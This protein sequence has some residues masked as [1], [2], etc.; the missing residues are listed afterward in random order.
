MYH[1]H[2]FVSIIIGFSVLAFVGCSNP[3]SKYSKVEGTVTLDGQP[4]EGVTVTF[5]P[6]EQGLEG[7]VGRTNASGQFSLTSTG[8][9]QGG[10]GVLPGEYRVTVSKSQ[11]PVDPDVEA[12]EQG[13]ITY[14]EVQKRMDARDPSRQLEAK[15]L[16]PEKYTKL[17][18]TDL[19]AMVKNGNNEPFIFDLTK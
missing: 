3:D 14:D 18:T 15:E 13:K 17:D 2:F 12:Y 8:A 16:L 11:P 9:L 19:T 1:K 7:A 5:Y 10:T 6:V 4:V